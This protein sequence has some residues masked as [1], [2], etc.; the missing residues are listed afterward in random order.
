MLDPLDYLL[1][2]NLLTRLPVTDPNWL[3][4]EDED[5]LI[6]ATPISVTRD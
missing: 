3:K 1:I 5:G 6:R 2:G 4:R